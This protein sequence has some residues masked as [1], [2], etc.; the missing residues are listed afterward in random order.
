MFSDFKMHVAGVPQIAPE[1]GVS[2]S[3]MIYDGPGE[4][5]DFGLEQIT[6]NPNDRYKFRSSP[7]R[8]AALQP[9]F[10]HNGAF[11]RIE[12]AIRHHLNVYESA[13]QYDASRAGVDK[14][15]RHRLGPIEPV[16]ARIDPLLA[17]P[18]RLSE[19]EFNDLVKFVRDSLL[20]DGAK[21]RELCPL[22]PKSVPSGLPMLRFQGCHRGDG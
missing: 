3:N 18:V 10:F 21:A 14:D 12:D 7:L 22:I 8:N 2:K 4:D 1:F 11:T 19:N 16:L 13:R 20:D 15:L 9:A 17:T 6:G 5:E